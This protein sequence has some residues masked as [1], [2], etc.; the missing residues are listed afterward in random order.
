[1]KPIARFANSSD[2]E[3]IIGLW[4]RFMQ[5]EKDAV[6]DARVGEVLDGWT[7]RLREQVRTSK[8]IVADIDGKTRGFLGFIDSTDRAWV[9]V[10][11]AYV[12]DIYVAPEARRSR[13]ALL[14]FRTLAGPTSK[15]TEIWTNTSVRN[16]RAQAFFA[17]AGF[18][19]M[20][21]FAIKGLEGQIYYRFSPTKAAP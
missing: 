7:Q 11:V 19:P 3:A 14:L 13:I 5:E 18:T 8:V 2:I 20:E 16:R 12:V 10:G 17:Q 21:G 6:P 15:Y 9:P 4:K 1:M